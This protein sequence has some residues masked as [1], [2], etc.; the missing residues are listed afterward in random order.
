MEYQVNR[1]N[2]IP[3]KLSVLQQ[4]AVSITPNGCN[5]NVKNGLE[6]TQPQVNTKHA[7]C[8]QV[9]DIHLHHE[10]IL[11]LFFFQNKYTLKGSDAIHIC[12]TY[13]SRILYAYS[14]C[15][16]TLHYLTCKEHRQDLNVCP[17]SHYGLLFKIRG[18]IILYQCSSF[19]EDM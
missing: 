11:K 5:R 4:P 2:L 8:K 14:I 16:L 7:F 9:G 15:Q 13:S 19:N 10:S 1:E 6:V 12:N 17:T 18:D 3:R